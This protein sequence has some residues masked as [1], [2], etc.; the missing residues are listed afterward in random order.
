MWFGGAQ[1]GRPAL[2]SLATGAAVGAG[3]GMLGHATTLLAAL[4]LRR[5]V[6]SS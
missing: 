6:T 2:E 4:H 3:A 1:E 5:F